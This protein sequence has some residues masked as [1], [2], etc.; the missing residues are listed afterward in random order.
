MLN[1]P[2]LHV[3]NINAYADFSQNPSILLKIL[4]GN[5]TLTSIKGHNSVL[6]THIKLNNPK[7]DAIN[8]IAYVKFGQNPS[9]PSRD[10]E[11]K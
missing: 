10:I 7:V 5:K 6:T 2:K 4:S 3:I 1:N 9:S 8:T 11:R